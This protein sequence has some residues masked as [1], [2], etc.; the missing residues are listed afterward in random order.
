M[1]YSIKERLLGVF[2]PQK[3]EKRYHS[4]LV[5]IFVNHGLEDAPNRW[6]KHTFDVSGD[7]YKEVVDRAIYVCLD[8]FSYEIAP[9]DDF[10]YKVDAVYEEILHSGKVDFPFLKEVA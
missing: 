7:T 1:I 10:K 2:K 5:D 6:D 9:N 8:K 3:K 4:F